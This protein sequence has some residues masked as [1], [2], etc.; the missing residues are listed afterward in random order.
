MALRFKSL[1]SGSSGNATVVEAGRAERNPIRVLVDCGLGIKALEVRL[2]EAKLTLADLHA[3]FI[4][5]EHGDH[6]GCAPALARRLKIPIWMSHGTFSAIGSPDLAGMLHVVRDGDQ[7]D[8]GELQLSPFTVPHDAREPLQ[9]TCTDGNT[10]LGILTDLGHAT[11]HVL[12][13]LS[14]CNAL[15]LECNHDTQLLEQS[16]YPAFLK[17]RIGG[18]HGHLSNAAAAEIAQAAHHSGLKHLVTAH[19][20]RENN[21][22]DLARLAISTALSCSN[23]DIVVADALNGSPWLSL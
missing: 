12:S 2:G 15:L 7:I 14:H 11:G 21:R 13:Q 23:D 18:L 16:A 10:K 3:I 6:V 4:T 22:P 17:R 5:H 19:L 20:S 1:G 8:L 9:L